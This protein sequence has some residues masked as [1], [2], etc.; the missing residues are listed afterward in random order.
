MLFCRWLLIIAVWNVSTEALYIL[1]YFLL[2]PLLSSSFLDEHPRI[3]LRACL[4]SYG[5]SV[6]GTSSLEADCWKLDRDQISR[7]H[8]DLLLQGFGNQVG[9]EECLWYV[10][11]YEQLF[12]RWSMPLFSNRPSSCSRRAPEIDAFDLCLVGCSRGRISSG[13]GWRHANHIWMSLRFV[14]NPGM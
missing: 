12:S 13:L 4:S 2:H 14:L 6:D 10:M 7:F 3:V 9:P 11:C 1:L 5:H 8:A